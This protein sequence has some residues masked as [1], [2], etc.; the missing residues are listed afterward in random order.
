[1]PD[2]KAVTKATI[3]GGKIG[4]L[5]PPIDTVRPPPPRLQRT[6]VIRFDNVP[7]GTVVDTLYAGNSV[8][9]ASLTTKPPSRGSAYARRLQIGTPS[10]GLNVLS[11][12]TSPG[13]TGAFFDARQ[14]AVEVTFDQLQSAVSV[15]AMPLDFPEAL[16]KDDNRPFMEAFDAA[17]TYLGRARTELGPDDPNFYLN[18]HLIAMNSPSR[19]IKTLRLSSQAQGSRWVYT[20][21]DNLTF[22]DNLLLTNP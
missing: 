20:V 19:N 8:K 18:W 7:D 3:L 15:M 5:R 6:V 21:F 2:P 9:F 10:S 16:G 12:T 4:A 14:G 17:G 1:M 11:L 13:W 22:R